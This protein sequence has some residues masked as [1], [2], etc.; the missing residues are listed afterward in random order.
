ML[1]YM[2]LCRFYK[3]DSFL[4]TLPDP[5]QTDPTL[6]HLKLYYSTRIRPAFSP[7]DTA[8]IHI[9]HEH[10]K[11]VY[12]CMFMTWYSFAAT[13]RDVPFTTLFYHQILRYTCMS[14]LFNVLSFRT[15][16]VMKGRSS[17]SVTLY[18][19]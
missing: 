15:Y 17:A 6:F 18:M 11:H 4:S 16:R 10:I 14:S 8:L 5:T 7:S 1:I 19:I 13:T 12:T 3:L 9:R 2:Y